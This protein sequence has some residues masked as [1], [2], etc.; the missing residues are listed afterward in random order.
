[1]ELVRKLPYDHPYR[2]DGTEFGFQKLWQPDELPSLVLW[3]D[4]EDSASITLNGSNVSQW[5]DKSGG[6][7]HFAQG[8]G[9]D[10]PLYS[11]TGFNGKP[12]I[13]NVSNDYLASSPN[14]LGRNVGGLTCA[15][16]GSH[17][18]GATFNP[19]T[20]DFFI[21][22]GVSN[23]RFLMTPSVGS[24]FYAIGGR[25]LD[26]DTYGTVSSSTDALA[27]RGNPWI[28]IG[29]RAYSDGVANHWTNGIQDV[30][31]A[32]FG[33]QG[34]G[35]TSDTNSNVSSVFFQGTNGTPPGTKMAEVIVT[36]ST[37][38]NQ[39]RQ[40]LEGYLAWKWGVEANLPAS[41]PYKL[42]PPTI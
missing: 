3:L 24:N 33:T 38:T 36:H 18:L 19:S 20:Y 34:A 22:S 9:A 10:Q 26:T 39:D 16:V 5:K 11:V 31:N 30:T 4:A 42:F 32:V 7:R 15:I 1:M 14:N 37:M 23:T 28:R 27:N 25:R 12:A 40:R 21:S 2:W 8:S 29:Q 41:H 35:N 17:P 13:E 6:N